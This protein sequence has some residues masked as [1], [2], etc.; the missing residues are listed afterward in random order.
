MK[1]S[2]KGQIGPFSLEVLFPLV[3]AVIVLTLFVAYLI[4]M[5]KNQV[6][7]RSVESTHDAALNMLQVLGEGSVLRHANTSG[8]LDYSSLSC[9]NVEKY[10]IT[11]Y[12]YSV[13][14]YDLKDGQNIRCGADPGNITSSRLAAPVAIFYERDRIHS[15][16]ITV[17]V[18]RKR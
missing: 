4:V 7:Q 18:W 5:T 1:S 10:S 12:N 17:Q 11:G 9:D 2:N 3:M 8:L 14:V 16:L 13:E 15:G 6:E